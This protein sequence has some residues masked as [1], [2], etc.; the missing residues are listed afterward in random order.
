MQVH[1]IIIIFHLRFVRELLR[2]GGACTPAVRVVRY[3]EVHAGRVPSPL[4]RHRPLRWC[5]PPAMSSTQ[6]VNFE[7]REIGVGSWTR[8]HNVF[9]V[10]VSS[11]G[12]LFIEIYTGR[13]R[14]RSACTFAPTDRHC[15]L[16]PL[17]EG[18]Q[19]TTFHFTTGFRRNCSRHDCCNVCYM[20][21]YH[22]PCTEFESSIGVEYSSTA[23]S[24]ALSD[25][26][27]GNI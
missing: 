18:T 14:A 15:Y 7:P 8:A 19:T 13:K 26:A 23:A 9:S 27:V 5:L 25:D 16:C 24:P 10:G 17:H 11:P 4:L 12:A 3:G 22:T 2:L 21:A 20:L 1:L 6:K